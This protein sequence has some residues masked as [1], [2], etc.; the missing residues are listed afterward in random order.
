M[1]PLASAAFHLRS[2]IPPFLLLLLAVTITAGALM[3]VRSALDGIRRRTC[4]P[5]AMAGLDCAVLAVLLEQA[6]LSPRLAACTAIPALVFA[7]L[8]AAASRIANRKADS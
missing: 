8:M 5:W 6:G 4:G 7:V 2:G 3:A 1:T